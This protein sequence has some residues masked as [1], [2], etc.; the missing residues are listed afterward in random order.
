M[1]TFRRHCVAVSSEERYTI[2]SSPKRYVTV[3]FR[4][5]NRFKHKIGGRSHKSR[6]C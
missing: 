5:L 4:N 3:L 2:Q 1:P 6:F